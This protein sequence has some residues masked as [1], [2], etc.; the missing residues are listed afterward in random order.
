[1]MGFSLSG[2]TENDIKQS[3]IAR[4][5]A[6]L[7]QTSRAARTLGKVRAAPFAVYTVPAGAVQTERTAV[8]P[9]TDSDRRERGG[10]AVSYTHLDVYKRQ[11]NGCS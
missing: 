6:K 3:R 8:R 11:Q 1:M 7:W 5:V 2:K 9:E 10:K 4:R